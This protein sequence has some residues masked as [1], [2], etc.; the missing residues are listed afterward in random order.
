MRVLALALTLTLFSAPLTAERCNQMKDF[1]QINFLFEVI[2]FGVNL[3]QPQIWSK[4]S[5]NLSP[6]ELF[7][8]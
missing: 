1:Y 6:N 3:H 7:L 2:R 8:S 4:P 5:Q